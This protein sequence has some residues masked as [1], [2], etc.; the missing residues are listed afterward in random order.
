MSQNVCYTLHFWPK[1]AHAGHYTGTAREPRLPERLTEHAQGL[2]ARITQVQVE[3]GGYWV[4]GNVQPGG[5]LRER[6]LKDMHN[7]ALHC[8]VCRAVEGFQSGKLSQEEALSRAGWNRAKP[9]ERKLLLE[10]FGIEPDLES[11]PARLPEVRPSRPVPEPQVQEEI[12]PE[13]NALVDAL[14]ADWAREARAEPEPEPDIA[15]LLEVPAPRWAPDVQM[16]QD[17][18]PGADAQIESWSPKAEAEP[19]LEIG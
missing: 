2:G 13:I 17:I 9:F 6:Q 4:L 8:D 11:T 1:L 14:C 18:T 19:E 5:R 15:R 16:Q 7:G 10:I 12:S 3:R